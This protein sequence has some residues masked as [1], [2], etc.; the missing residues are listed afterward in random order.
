MKL[1]GLLPRSWVVTRFAPRRRTLYLTFDDG[2]HP[3]HTPALL[4]LLARHD[5]RASFFAV[6]RQAEAHPDLVRRIVEEG[7]LLGNH[8]HSHPQFD[9]LSITEQLDEVARAEAVLAKFDG[10]KRHLV[11]PPRGELSL[12]MLWHYVRGRVPIAC[13]S[14][15][16]LDY[17]RYPASD[18]IAMAQRHPPR[19]GDVILLHDDAALS[20]DFLTTML[21]AW[22]QA[23]YA[24]EALP[25]HA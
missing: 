24:F 2:P 11:R 9:L 13:W 18:L 12:R 6:G 19:A 4:D 25:L 21:P 17:T 15:D 5:A 8:S 20:H 14:Y 22:K 23:G 10:R 3:A 7:H 16:S 1:L